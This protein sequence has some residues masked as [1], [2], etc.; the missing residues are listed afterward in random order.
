[1]TT[2]ER[3]HLIYGNTARAA[4]PAPAPSPEKPKKQKRQKRNV[5]SQNSFEIEWK[6]RKIYLAIIVI[7]FMC[8]SYVYLMAANIQIRKEI[9]GLKTELNT[10]Q[11]ENDDLES[12]IYSEVDDSEI[13]KKA[14]EKL[15]MVKPSE[16]HII[17]YSNEN[18]DYV[19]QYEAIPE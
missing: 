6:N 5:P 18:K 19:R 12:E 10:V 7:A 3:Y 2:E 15:G 8:I 16:D 17:K 9:A 1:M 13:K 4:E 14:T 11:I